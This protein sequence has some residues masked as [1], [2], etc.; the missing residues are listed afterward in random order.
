[1]KP[2]RI[3]AI[4]WSV[5][6]WPI[7]WDL[8]AAFDNL[9]YQALL[10]IAY[11]LWQPHALL[12]TVAYYINQ[13]N[14]LLTARLLPLVLNVVV[15]FLSETDI[16]RTVAILAIMVAALGIIA[17]YLQIQLVDLRKFFLYAVL[18]SL[19]LTQGPQVMA[20]IEQAR[21]NVAHAVYERAYASVSS[22]PELANAVSGPP[23]TE[24]WAQFSLLPYYQPGF[25]AHDAALSALAVSQGEEMLPGLPVGM[26]G[27]FFSPSNISKLSEAERTDAL[28]RATHGVMRLLLSYPLSIV[29]VLE[30]VVELLFSIAGFFLLI[31]IPFALLFSF[32]LPTEGIAVSLLRQYA[33]LFLN[34]VVVSVMMSIGV[35]ALAIAASR[36]SITLVVGGAVFTGVFYFFGFNV[37]KQAVRSSFTALSGSIASVMGTR[38]PVA[39]AMQGVQQ[40]FGLGVGAVGA[41]LAIAAGAPMLAPAALSAGAG[42]AGEGEDGRGI[43]KA[44]GLLRTGLG[45]LGGQLMQGTP[46]AELATGAAM[47]RSMGGG[48]LM[49]MVDQLDA[50]D[51]TLVGLT[52]RADNP[53][54]LAISLDRALARKERMQRK[55]TVADEGA[56]TGDGSGG[57]SGDET[58]CSQYTPN[59]ASP[60]SAQVDR[61]VQKHGEEWAQQVA[62]AVVNAVEELRQK[63]IGEGD[64]ARYF[65]NTQGAPDLRSPGGR[66]VFDSLD[67]RVRA[68]LASPEAQAGVAG[69]IG[70]TVMPRVVVPREALVDAIAEAVESGATKGA[71]AVA[72]RLG[73]APSALGSSYSAVNAIVSHAQAMGLSASDTRLVL[74]TGMIPPSQAGNPDVERLTEMR[75]LLPDSLTVIRT[76]IP[77]AG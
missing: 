62:R 41:G 73:S 58:A 32:F 75:A 23:A 71:E 20:Q 15:S 77:P 9:M 65:V 55:Y 17:S 19:V 67:P 51:A 6:T 60:W 24:P 35:A 12:L 7:P 48:G 70:D 31:S 30:A 22:S 59:P 64:L 74:R 11:W 25:S 34:Y 29:A 66:S 38:D 28:N 8:S 52:T 21:R 14:T 47:L 44:K 5:A 69:I 57:A 1:M 53:L 72:A 3:G 43:E 61:A 46:L 10:F 68:T 63:G 36:G 16:F 39:L 54:A 56:D 49:G 27:Q 42:L 76:N 40:A 37:A 18:S 33:M 13:I 50:A 4:V 45:V 26:T 2:S